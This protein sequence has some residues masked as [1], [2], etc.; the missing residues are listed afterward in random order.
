MF[1]TFMFICWTDYKYTRCTTYKKNTWSRNLKISLNLRPSISALVMIWFTSY[2]TSFPIHNIKNN[3]HNNHQTNTDETLHTWASE[4]GKLSVIHQMFKH[5]VS[6]LVWH[7]SEDVGNA[8]LQEALV[9]GHELGHEGLEMVDGL[10]AHLQPVLEL[11]SR[12]DHLGLELAV[13][14]GYHVLQET[15]YTKELATILCRGS[16]K[17]QSHFRVWQKCMRAC[18]PL[19][20]CLHMQI[21]IRGTN[22]SGN[23]SLMNICVCEHMSIGSRTLLLYAIK[24]L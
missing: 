14:A 20:I 1:N 7:W 4:F 21:C 2:F 12:L 16:L 3:L 19:I 17:L 10:L 6:T 15:L 23:I 8:L 22:V 5:N 18:A 11:G 24:W 9:D 13:T